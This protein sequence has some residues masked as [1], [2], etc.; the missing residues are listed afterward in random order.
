MSRLMSRFMTPSSVWARLG[1]H[2]LKPK[3]SRQLE[4]VQYNRLSCV[5]HFYMCSDTNQQNLLGV[6][7]HID[8]F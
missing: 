2:S 3:K 6:F 4:W 1:L 8:R 5:G 7:W